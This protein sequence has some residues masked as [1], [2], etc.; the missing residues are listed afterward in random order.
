MIIF[1]PTGCQRLQSTSGSAVIIVGIYVSRSAAEALESEWKEK[2][3]F[4]DEEKKRSLKLSACT[5]ALRQ[6]ASCTNKNKTEKLLGR[7]VFRMTSYRTNNF[8]R[9]FRFN[10]FAFLYLARVST[11]EQDIRRPR[12]QVRS[13]D[14]ALVS[15]RFEVILGLLF[16]SFNRRWRTRFLNLMAQQ[17]CK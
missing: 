9:V 17:I 14:N 3:F 15:S 10:T 11:C 8:D 1:K 7:K 16:P 6:G 12:H 13:A 4:C 5:S 2:E